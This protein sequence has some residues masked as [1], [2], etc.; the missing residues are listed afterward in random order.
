MVGLLTA[1]AA[2][3][4]SP[5]DAPTSEATAAVVSITGTAAEAPELNYPVPLTLDAPITEVVW[6]GDGD[7]VVEGEPVLL[8]VYSENG[9]DGTAARNDFL[10][11]PVPYLLTEEAIGSDLFDVLSGHRVGAR[12]LHAVETDGVPIVTSI[13][14]LPTRAVGDLSAPEAGMP[15]VA[16]DGVGA[17]TVT[18]PS[19]QPAPTAP[20]V[21]QV[22][23]GTGEQVP[24]GSKVV[25]QFVVVKWSTGEV[26][27][28]TWGEGRLPKTVT[29]G[30]DQ[31]IEGFD[32][33]LVD[34]PVGSQVML[35]VPPGLGF[36]PSGNDLSA[37]TLV[38]VVDILAVSPAAPTG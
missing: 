5:D 11:V 27:D 37:E 9:T 14:I 2:C 35:V 32:E 3:G 10:S 1:T 20:V 15:V 12:I 33:G 26:Y 16:H 24:S 25:I 6:E 34:L 23:R 22:V 7:E 28:T 17:P 29:V 38:Y 30:A 8:R 18:I 13:D 31:L 19:D 4:P 36:G 21:R